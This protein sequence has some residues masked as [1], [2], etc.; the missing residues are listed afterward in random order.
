MWGGMVHQYHID[1]GTHIEADN[2]DRDEK[3]FTARVL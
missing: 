3:A 1:G 2:E